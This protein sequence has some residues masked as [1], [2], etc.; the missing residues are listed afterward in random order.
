LQASQPGE[1]EHQ[2]LVVDCALVEDLPQEQ[3]YALGV[4]G[5]ATKKE[6][7]WWILYEPSQELQR[8]MK[9]MKQS[10]QNDSLEDE[11]RRTNEQK[12]VGMNV[13]EDEALSYER[14]EKE[15]TTHNVCTRQIMDHANRLKCS[16]YQQ[17]R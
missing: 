17:K 11:E 9:G 3:P 1:K 2:G 8:K 6:G 4:E 7:S 5:F 15:K 13:T 10:Q 12:F 16:K 14:G